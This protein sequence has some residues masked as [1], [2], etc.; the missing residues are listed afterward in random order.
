[1]ADKIIY[2]SEF[3]SETLMIVYQSIYKSE[4]KHY[5]GIWYWTEC[6]SEADWKIYFTTYKS[7]ADLII[8]FTEYKS[9][10]G[11]K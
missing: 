7:E 9:E 10:D 4:A 2:V 5:S 11:M 1:M 6:M 3:K 8:F